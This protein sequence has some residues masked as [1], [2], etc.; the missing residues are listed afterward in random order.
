MSSVPFGN[1]VASKIT[2]FIHRRFSNDTKAGK[3][4]SWRLW[5]SE[6]AKK[7]AKR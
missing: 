5:S 6:V 1:L 2:T 7:L 4:W 3:L